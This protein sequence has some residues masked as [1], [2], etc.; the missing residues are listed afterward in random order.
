MD[1]DKVLDRKHM[2]N[3]VLLVRASNR[4]VFSMSDRI[5]GI[6]YRPYLSELRRCYALL[7]NSNLDIYRPPRMYLNCVPL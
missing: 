3:L 1:N 2:R 4:L 7:L 5:L 6:T